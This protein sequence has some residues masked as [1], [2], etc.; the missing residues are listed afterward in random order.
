MGWS[1]GYYF[2]FL[3]SLLKHTLDSVFETLPIVFFPLFK[4][5]LDSLLK[6]LP[7]VFN[8][9]IIL[10]DFYGSVLV[11]QADFLGALSLLAVKDHAMLNSLLI[12][13]NLA[14]KKFEVEGNFLIVIKWILFLLFLGTLGNVFW[15]LKQFYHPLM[16]WC[17]VMSIKR[18]LFIL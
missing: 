15:I 1:R 14:T 10:R 13:S 9:G 3:F 5:A 8:F 16:S 12:T 7:K 11:P 6:M 2:F 17:L 4:H 18:T